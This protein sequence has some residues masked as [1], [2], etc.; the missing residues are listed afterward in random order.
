MRA[1]TI[2]TS[3]MRMMRASA[4]AVFCLMAA[5]CDS[6]SPSGPTPSGLQVSGIAP[7]SGSTTGGN[8]VTITGIGFGADATVVIGGVAATNIVVSGGTTITAT[9]AAR[10]GAGAAD[11]SVTSGGRTST[12]PAAFTFIAPTGT[13]SPPAIA[14]FR[15]VGSRA[16]Q[17]SGFA[18]VDESVQ[19]L[20]TVT[21]TE[22]ATSALTFAWTGPGTLTSGGSTL[23]WK[24]PPSFSQGTPATAT[25]GLT[26]TEV[27]TEGGVQHQHSTIGSF[28][29]RVHDSQKEIIDAGQDFLLLF[30][31]STY[32]PDAVLHNFSTTCDGGNGRAEEFTD[33]ARNRRDVVE[34]A[35]AARIAARPPATITFRSRCVLPDGRVQP[36]IDACISYTAHW[37]DT[38]RATGA[39]TMTDGIDYVSAV[40]ENDRWWLCHSSFI[41]T[42]RNPLTG[43]VRALRW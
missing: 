14:G 17:P 22:T 39:R 30:S 26:V 35:A 6:C 12:R 38:N 18:D 7:A 41:G 28:A 11:V 2:Q 19:V 31:D 24:V 10:P 1:G 37:E 4:C 40:L 5:A 21:D 15:S 42:S 43:E 9:T 27:F 32:P 36:N 29:M 13:N 33:V 3:F 8:S 34:N 23:S 16:N 25:L 20:A